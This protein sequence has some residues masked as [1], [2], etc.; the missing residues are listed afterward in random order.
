[1]VSIELITTYQMKPPTVHG[2]LSWWRENNWNERRKRNVKTL[3]P[4][5]PT[6]RGRLIF[7]RL[8]SAGRMY[9]YIHTLSEHKISL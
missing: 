9:T 8:W 5:L 1:V 7:S 4:N 3:H 2:W 6:I